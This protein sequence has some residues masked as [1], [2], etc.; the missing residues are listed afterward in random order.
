MNTPVAL[1]ALAAAAL[2]GWTTEAGAAQTARPPVKDRRPAK[3][4]APPAKAPAETLK[5]GADV[6]RKDF[7]AAVKL[8]Y[9]FQIQD[10]NVKA[11][12]RVAVGS[13]LTVWRWRPTHQN[14]Q[15]FRFHA[16]GG[17]KYRIETL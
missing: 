11:N 13:D 7:D 16:L 8:G 17:G 9:T 15:R 10:P 4:K 12:Y 1:L 14:D 5:P 3:S 2:A 6:T